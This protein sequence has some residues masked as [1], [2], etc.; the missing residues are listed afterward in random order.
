M[1]DSRQQVD[2]ILDGDERAFEQFVNDHKR[3]VGQIVAKMGVNPAD[4]EDLCQDVFVKVYRN[5]RK[6]EFR[7][8]LSTWVA[9]IAYNS[10]VNYLQKKKVPVFGDREHEFA[11]EDT[12][13]ITT[14]GPDELAE[15]NDVAVRLR[16]EIDRLPAHYRTVLSL[17][18]LKDMAYA[19]IAGVTKLPEGTIKSHLFRA[20]KLLKE[21]LMARYQPEEIWA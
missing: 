9:Q 8:K 18:H 17:F 19:E 16:A 20:R 6:F 4:H 12:W 21:R 11:H 2:Q 3:L 10:S 1:S 7:C 5:L 15:R 13:P 14:A